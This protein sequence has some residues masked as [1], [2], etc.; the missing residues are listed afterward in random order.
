MVVEL[1]CKTRMTIGELTRRGIAA[2]EIA[3]TLDVTE[4]VVRYHLRRQATGAIDGRSQQR[5]RI[6]IEDWEAAISEATKHERATETGRGDG[7]RVS[8]HLATT[9]VCAA[10]SGQT[11]LSSPGEGA[12]LI[13]L[14]AG[15][16]PAG[17]AQPAPT[18]RTHKTAGRASERSRGLPDAIDSCRLRT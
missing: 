3:R 7:R 6:R 5:F 1:G 12:V 18:T 13:G 10:Q 15:C 9:G 14:S 4:A 16:N 8:R 17:G 2:S 11:C